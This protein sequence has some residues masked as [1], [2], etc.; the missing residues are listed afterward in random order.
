VSSGRIL[1][2]DDQIALAENIAEVLQGLGFETLVAAS[3]EEALAIV[4]GGGISAVVTDFR[5]PGR[6]GADLIGDLRRAG[7]RIPVLMMSAYT[8]EQTIAQSHAA[9]AWLFLPKPVPLDVLM[10]VVQSLAK[11]PAAALVIDDE[12]SFAD[13][14][15]EALTAEGHEVIVSQTAADALAQHRRLDTAVVDYR[16]PDGTGIDVARAL[17]ARDPAIRILFISGFA[18]ELRGRLAAELPGSEAMAKPVDMR[19]VIAWL[20]L[21]AKNQG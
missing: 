14:L 3:A 21:G 12:A 16:L 7:E 8:D 9:G 11:T 18:D 4:R 1:V 5:L 19:S 13:N 2:V 17:R 6:S 20:A 10:D 15:A